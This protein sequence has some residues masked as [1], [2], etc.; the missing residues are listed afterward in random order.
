[1]T[2]VAKRYCTLYRIGHWGSLEAECETWLDQLGATNHSLTFRLINMF[3]ER[4]FMG[5]AHI[6]ET[7]GDVPTFSDED[8]ERFPDLET[9]VRAHA[10]ELVKVTEIPGPWRDGRRVTTRGKARW[11]RR[12]ID[13]RAGGPR[14]TP[15]AA[16]RRSCS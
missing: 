11:R 8:G 3:G 5:S 2:D 9:A 1:M 6:S 10:T 13:D 4:C 12:S 15:A 7:R 14:R 16:S